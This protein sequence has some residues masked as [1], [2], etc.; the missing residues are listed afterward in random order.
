MKSKHSNNAISTPAS[1][2]GPTR[3]GSPAGPTIDL[4]GPDP[5]PANPSALPASNADSTMNATS[6]RNG[7]V[8]SASANLSWH[9]GNR[10]QTALGSL[11]STLYKVT[12]KIRVTPAGRP[13]FA[14]RASVRRTSG[15]GSGL[16]LKGWATPNARDYRSNS[17]SPKY[18]SRRAAQTRGKGLEEQAH[19]LAGWPTPTGPAPHDSENT[20]G[21]ARPR[22]GYGMDLPIAASIAG[23]P[24]EH[25]T[26]PRCPIRFKVSGEML[27]GSDAG[28]ESSGQLNPAHSRWLMGLPPEWDDC[29]V[30]AMQSMRK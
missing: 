26:T 20:A 30:T 4:F 23:W 8:S 19:Q 25:M 10:L 24:R 21:K 29:A 18:H 17:A 13:I 5:A 12:W 28:M 2:S 3:S 11:G 27:I 15:N 16:S 9:L 22:K 14:L 6:G 1:A 7:I